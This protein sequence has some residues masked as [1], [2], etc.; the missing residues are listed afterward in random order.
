MLEVL[1]AHK[2]ARSSHCSY[3]HD[4]VGLGLIL[5]QK[6]N[7]HASVKNVIVACVGT[8]ELALILSSLDTCIAVLGSAALASAAKYVRRVWGCLYCLLC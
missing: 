4:G 7:V 5:L 1:N 2:K 6:L 8:P 3:K